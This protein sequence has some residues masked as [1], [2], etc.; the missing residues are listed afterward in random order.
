MSGKRVARLDR[1]VTDGS[2]DRASGGSD[3]LFPCA[4]ETI[5]RSA[6]LPKNAD[7]PLP[8]SISLPFPTAHTGSCLVDW[9]AMP[10]A[11]SGFGPREQRKRHEKTPLTPLTPC[12]V[13]SFCGFGILPDP[14]KTNVWELCRSP[15]PWR[16]GWFSRS[17]IRWFG[18][19]VPVRRRDHRAIRI[20]PKK[21]GWP[22]AAF[23][24]SPVPDRP[25]RLVPRRLA[26]HAVGSIRLRTARAEETAR[27]NSA[28]S[29]DSV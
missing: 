1:G 29:V 24:L 21:R 23:H 15:R 28:H 11:R 26:R 18:R 7:G 25:H 12:E 22:P 20:P 10:S 17:R 16:D 8:H 27:E 9:R 4:A 6:S 19:P 2:Q 3:G 13:H 14:E 5:G